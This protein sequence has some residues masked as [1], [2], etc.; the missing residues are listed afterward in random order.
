MFIIFPLN[1]GTH[2]ECC[3]K[4]GITTRVS[5][6]QDVFHVFIFI[7]YVHDEEPKTRVGYRGLDI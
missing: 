3:L 2:W 1:T 6:V 7:I 5:R 4:V